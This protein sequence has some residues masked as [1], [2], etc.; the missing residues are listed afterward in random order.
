MRATNEEYAMKY[1]GYMVER[2]CPECG[3]M[4]KR[5]VSEFELRQTYGVVGSVYCDNCEKENRKR[6][7]KKQ[8]EHDRDHPLVSCGSCDGK[9]TINGYYTAPH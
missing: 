7:Q 4:V 6:Q 1:E 9:G 3:K 2:P 5:V 8:E